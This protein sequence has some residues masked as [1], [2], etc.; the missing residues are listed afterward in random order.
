MRSTIV[1]IPY[2]PNYLPKPTVTRHTSN[3]DHTFIFSFFFILPS[4]ISTRDDTTLGQGHFGLFLEDDVF[5]I[6]TDSAQSRT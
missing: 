4:S 6:P 5:I 3:E 2:G 1:S